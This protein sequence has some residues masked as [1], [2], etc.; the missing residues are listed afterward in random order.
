ML[1][2]FFATPR[3]DCLDSEGMVVCWVEIQALRDGELRGMDWMAGEV[4]LDL[5]G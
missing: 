1:Q 3:G 5:V 4:C 2:S